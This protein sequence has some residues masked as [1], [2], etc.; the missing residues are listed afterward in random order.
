MATLR[1]VPQRTRNSRSI[2]F[3]P[4]GDLVLTSDGGVYV[5]TQPQ[6]NTGIWTNANGASVFETYAVGYDAVGKRLITAAQD[7]GVTIQSAR[8]SQSWNAV[9][10]ADGINAF[11]ND[12]T[13]AGSGRSAFYANVQSL[14]GPARIILDAQGNIVSPNTAVFFGFGTNV[15]CNGIACS[16]AVSGTWFWSPWINNKVDATR[17]ALGGNH[18]YVTQDTLTGAN[19]PNANTVDLT[20]I[21]LGAV[22]GGAASVTKIAY[23]TRDNPNVLV[24]GIAPSGRRGGGAG[25]LWL[26]AT[27]TAGSIAQLPAYAALGAFAPTGIVF[28]P[29]SQIAS[30]WQTATKC[31]GTQN[32]GAAFTNLTAF[33][34]GGI[35][36]PTATEFISNNGV[37]ALLVGGLNN[38]ANAQS[39]IA[40][41][42]SDGNG[43]LSNWRFFGQRLANS[44]VGQL[45]YNPAVDVLAVGTFGRGIFTLYDVTSYF[46]QALTLQFGRA[47]NNSVPDASFLTD[48]SVGSRPLIKYGTGTLTIAGD[49]TY[50][51]PTF[52]NGGIL[53]VNGSIVSPVFVN[54]GGALGGNGTVG[55][56]TIFNGGTLSPGNLVGTITVNGNLLFSPGSLYF[57]EVFGNTA[58]RTN[59]TG[60]AT[61]A[62]TVAAVF[63]GGNLTNRYTIISAAGGVTDTFGNLISVGGPAFITTSLG[64]TPTT[65]ELDLT[66]GLSQIAG[67]TRNQA[68]VAAAL[69]NSF[70]LGRGT[71]PALFGVPLSQLPQAMSALSGEGIS[72]AQETAFGASSVFTSLMMDQGAFWRSGSPVDPNGVAFVEDAKTKTSSRSTTRRR[73]PFRPPFTCPAGGLGSPDTTRHGNLTAKRASE[74][75]A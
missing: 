42:D 43:N 29:R 37:N 73:P 56:T 7:N 54:S 23:G 39:T 55:S 48:G 13:L 64:Y 49:A 72:G 31:F 67:L 47:N 52:V 36:R 28:D 10:G 26:S 14:G 1:M 15:T 27:G 62:G 30:M 61:L 50:S 60:T 63:T 35:I 17:M 45:A 11:V 58:D 57:V 5:R 59:V 74:A 9:M 18:V 34:P 75:P 41:A 20:L 19:A 32:Q 6:S 65:A 16:N 46:P 44:Q 24:A 68:A 12:A 70:N 51:G 3:L 66:S 53:T 71:L 21:D 38:V 40:V 33:L 2:A 25:Q 69:D 8:N 4:N 22:G